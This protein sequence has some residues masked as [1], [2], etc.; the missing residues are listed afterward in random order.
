ML[1]GAAAL[2]ILSGG[3]PGGGSSLSALNLFRQINKNEAQLRENYFNRKDV[4]QS[5]EAFKTK[6]SK[7]EDIDALV[8]DRK[9]LQFLLSSFDLDSEINNAGKIKAILKSDI[10][11]Q[12]SFANRL[13]DKRFAELA[14]FVDFKEKGFKNLR[15][16]SSQQKLIDKFLQN[17]FE[18]DVS[19][20]NTDIAKAFHFL[21]NI[22]NVS[23]TSSLLGTLQLREIVTTALR[24]PQEIARQSID[25]QIS[26]VEAKFDVKKAVISDQSSGISNFRQSRF[27]DD[28]QAIEIAKSQAI[29][30]ENALS[31]LD[32]RLR[33]ARERLKLL[34]EIS[35]PDGFN[36]NRIPIHQTAVKQ[37]SEINGV[38][39]AA[40]S[41]IEELD[42]ILKGLDERA[43]QVLVVETQ[44]DLDN[45]KAGFAEE[46]AKISD[47]IYHTARFRD[48]DTNT[49]IN[50]FKPSG[51]VVDAGS[52][53]SYT[54]ARI[55]YAYQDGT[56][57]NNPITTLSGPLGAN[58]YTVQSGTL[59]SNP[60][61]VQSATLGSNP[62]TVQSGT[63]GSNPFTV[64]SSTLGSNPFTIKGG[65]LVVNPW[66][67]FAN[68]TPNRDSDKTAILK[69]RIPHHGLQAGDKITVSGTTNAFGADLNGTYTVHSVRTSDVIYI[70]VGVDLGS[71][72]ATHESAGG[73][74]GTFV[75]NRVQVNHTGHPFSDGDTATFSGASSVGDR[76]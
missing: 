49:N 3:S 20:Q 63:L 5:I 70:D 7:F 13:N 67:W 8:K 57:D 59:G 60:Y 30:A 38:T 19:G 72:P 53:N 46:A 75:T 22:N 40:R 43:K 39:A 51:G 61:T 65:D 62:Y 47:L 15:T 1:N 52:P 14:N 32:R 37:L 66:R 54:A 36:A 6:I 12:N 10:N 21:R 31:S 27:E 11:D 24:L 45:L 16:A 56:L 35:S 34:P 23:T 17:T 71:P 64:E 28:I 68:H 44:E 74:S 18:K 55:N 73:N 41:A 9:S 4:Q 33:N 76:A 26:M 42:P 50:L 25:K 2:G 69:I 29:S 58:P 48:P